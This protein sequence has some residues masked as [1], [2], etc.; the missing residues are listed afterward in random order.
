M[1]RWILRAAIFF[2]GLAVLSAAGF[3][4]A[5]ADVA[6][7]DMPRVLLWLAIAAFAIF[8]LLL[9]FGTWRKWRKARRVRK[10]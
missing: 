9:S 3:L 10:D 7:S 1:S 5:A 8:S 4:L 2:C 6:D